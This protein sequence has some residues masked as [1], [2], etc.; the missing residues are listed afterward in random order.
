M[1]R[2]LPIGL[3][4]LIALVLFS[5]CV[6]VVDQRQYAI[7]LS[8]QEVRQVIDKPGLYVKLPPPFQN[9]IYFDKRILTM[10]TQ[11][12]D[13]FFTAEKKN[14]QVDT[15]VK[16][17]ILDPK[18]YL[19]SV[20][21]N[22]ITAGDRIS[23]S[24]RDVL[25]NEIGKRTIN[26]V[27]SGERE[28][29][30]VDISNR[31]NQDAKEKKMGVEIVDV[32]LKR[33]EFAP[34]ISDSVYR[35]MQS[36]RQRVASELRSTGKAESDKIRAD[37]HKQREVIVAEAYRDA[38]RIKGEGDAKATAIYGQAF[39]QNPEFYAFYRSLDAYRAS[40]KNRSDIMVV[41]P[42]SEFF[43]YMKNGAT[44]GVTVAPRGK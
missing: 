3:L 33:V 14:I 11:E 44:G 2:I 39:G 8:F 37:A 43:K 32:R 31:L 26:E 20:G 38:Q 42:S 10:D 28:K 23:R 25:N 40:F 13:R 34:E 41:D 9:V 5:T 27:I 7:V 22:E 12:V 16:W 6:F 35:Q 18:Q 29:L 17:R 19:V 30:M 1:N 4:T 24:L 36:E 21:G 15:F